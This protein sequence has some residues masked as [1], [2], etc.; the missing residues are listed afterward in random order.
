[1]DG[2]NEISRDR[3][4][5]ESAA[6]GSAFGK[7][8]ELTLE[9]EYPDLATYERE[10]QAFYSDAEAM[11]LWRQSSEHLVQGYSELIESASQVA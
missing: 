10:T 9:T 1:M 8:N 4:W 3:G 6:W 5:K 2:L 11:A 7:F